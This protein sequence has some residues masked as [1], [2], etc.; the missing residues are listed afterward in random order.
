MTLLPRYEPCAILQSKGIPCLIWFEDA[1][2]QYGVPTVVFDLYL[3]VPDIDTAAGVLAENGWT[4]AGPPN[5]YHILTQ[6]P[7][8][9]HRRL[10]PPCKAETPI[11]PSDSPDMKPPGPGTTILLPAADWN[12]PIEKLGSDGIVPP[13]PVLVDAL[14][15]SLLDAPH[16]SPLQRHVGTQIVYLYG[17]CSSLDSK[18]FAD[19]LKFE[20]RQF[21][22]D[23]RLKRNWSLPFKAIER[24]IRDELRKGQRHELQE[25]GSTEFLNMAVP[26]PPKL[27]DPVD[28][29]SEEEEEDEVEEVEK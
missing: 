29:S 5:E 10:D 13:L 11:A 2:G 8:I 12:V 18:E 24:S 15:E 7:F 21:H 27:P 6:C 26:V 1:I 14:I 19:C 4:K 9:S 22:Y 25:D 3:L 20:N 28:Y 16:G 17:H 23:A